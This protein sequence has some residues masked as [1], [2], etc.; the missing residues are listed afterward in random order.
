MTTPSRRAPVA[1]AGAA[2]VLTLAAAC[3]I[4]SRPLW[5]PHPQHARPT[6]G[7]T[8]SGDQTASGPAVRHPWHQGMRQL[9]IHVYWT[10][11]RSDASDAVTWA[12]AQRIIDY[13]ISLN[14]NS[15]AVT[16]P[17][18]TYGPTSDTVY[19]KPT[20]T[21]SPSHIAIF[22]AAAAKAHIR[23][24]LRPV[25]DE[26]A[27]LAHGPQDWRGSIEPQDRAAWFRSY[28]KLLLPY[29]AA[30]QAGHAAT[31]VLGTELLS[32]EGAPQ[33]P[34]LVSSLRSVYGGELT[35]DENYDEFAWG[36]AHPPVPSHNVD[37]YPRL[38]LPDNASVAS[39]TQGWDAWLGAH[40][41]SERRELILSEIGLDAVAG[42]YQNP[43]AWFRRTT[44][45]IDTRVQAAWY[46]AAC[47][48]VSA[49]Q[50]GGGIYW[51]EVNFDASPGDPGPF[52]SDRLT[53]LDR[54]AQQVIRNCF[55]KL[56]SQVV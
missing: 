31:F 35:Y 46:Q 17:F 54:P 3:S 36:T 19:A 40:P 10:A 7:D 28:R 51:Y 21:P 6:A 23:V 30:A 12:K 26:S 47:D 4:P 15:V 14:A 13:A 11:N 56:S 37:A 24:T 50:I 45:P 42:S 39:L 2:L 55:A 1:A 48:A 20:V 18:F 53:F 5:W 16:F 33:W 49:E 41:L 38:G 8:A 25:L 27:L 43:W 52:E 22:L 9:G 32:L 34:G 29:V 44:A